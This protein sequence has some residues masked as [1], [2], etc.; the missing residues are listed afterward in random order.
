MRDKTLEELLR[1]LEEASR[2]CIDAVDETPP[3]I[4]CIKLDFG[5]TAQVL[6]VSKN[7]S[8]GSRSK[9]FRSY[10]QGTVQQASYPH[11]GMPPPRLDNRL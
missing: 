9:Q 7:Q 1:M 10:T 3:H 6:P 5:V 8:N 4:F 2:E 11:G